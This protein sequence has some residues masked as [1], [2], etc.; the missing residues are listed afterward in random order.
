MYQTPLA[1][2]LPLPSKAHPTDVGWDIATAV[3]F[4]AEPGKPVKVPTGLVIDMPDYIFTTGWLWWKKRWVLSFVV[5]P[6]TGH[7]SRGFQP[8]ATE[9]DTGYRPVRG[10][11]N[12]WVLCLCNLSDE[13]MEFK[14]GDRVAQIVP[15]LVCA[16]PWVPITEAQVKW[17]TKRGSKRF[18]ATG[19]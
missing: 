8:F 1:E 11:I 6:R 9:F 10:D 16:E 5:K 17:L 2:G 18:G 7:G 14:R 19:K 4:V 3:D 15:T 13:P 12:G